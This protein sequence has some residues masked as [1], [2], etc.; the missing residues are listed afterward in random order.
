[1]NDDAIFALA[2]VAADQS[3]PA[4]K[5]DA[6]MSALRFAHKLT[7]SPQAMTDADIEALLAHF[8][9]QQVAEIVYHVGIAAFLDRVTESAGLGWNDEPAAA[10]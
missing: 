2:E 8:T 3:E 7:A 4:S 5:P 10:T 1:M 9:P 6:S